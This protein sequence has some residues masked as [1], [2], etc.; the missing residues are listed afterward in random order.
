MVDEI[1]PSSIINFYY[2]FMA[3]MMNPE[4]SSSDRKVAMVLTHLNVIW[5]CSFQK[6]PP[7]IVQSINSIVFEGVREL[8]LGQIVPNIIPTG[9]PYCMQYSGDVNFLNEEMVIVPT[10]DLMRYLYNSI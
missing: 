3:L 1:M 9:L 8:F 10:N 5:K 6:E 4:L 7:S 2:Y